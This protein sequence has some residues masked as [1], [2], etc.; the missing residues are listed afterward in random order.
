MCHGLTKE[1]CRSVFFE[2]EHSI[3]MGESL[4]KFHELL[5]FNSKFFIVADE[6]RKREY[7]EEMK[8]SVYSQLKDRVKFY[9]YGKLS[10]WH[11]ACA[12]NMVYSPL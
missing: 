6:Q 12:A 3:R 5:D 10:K 1:K 8:S 11:S 9:D 7:E 4:R 2:V